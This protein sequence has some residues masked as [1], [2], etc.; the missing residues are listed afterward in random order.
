MLTR[1]DKILIASVLVFAVAIFT[2]FQIYGFG[3]GRTYAVIEVDGR[4]YQKISLGSDGPKLQLKVPGVLGELIIEVDRDRVRVVSADCPD[5]DCI[6]QGWASR[7]GQML[8]CLPNR[9]VVKIESEKSPEG[10]DVV[11]F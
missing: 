6:R 3:G 9:V 7:P 2:G 10:P 4:Q 11:S 8:V 1:G 5:K